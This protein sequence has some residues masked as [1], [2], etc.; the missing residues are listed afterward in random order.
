MKP[1]AIIALTIALTTT[2]CLG[3]PTPPDVSELPS[4]HLIPPG[5]NEHTH[6]DLFAQLMREYW[7][8]Q[9]TLAEIA[10]RRAVDVGLPLLVIGAIVYALRRNAK[11]KRERRDE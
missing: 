3:N 8:A 1:I 7:D 11:S 4:Y 9:P 2:A 6:P 5:A 10:A